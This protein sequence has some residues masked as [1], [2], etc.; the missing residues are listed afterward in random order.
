ME[1]KAE[2]EEEAEEEEEQQ[3]QPSTP[4]QRARQLRLPAGRTAEGQNCRTQWAGRISCRD[5]LGTRSPE[6][7]GRISARPGVLEPSVGLLGFKSS[8]EMP[9]S[10]NRPRCAKI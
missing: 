9:N 3:Q 4:Q 1:A 10:S 6:L 2:V 7:S 5:R 8:L